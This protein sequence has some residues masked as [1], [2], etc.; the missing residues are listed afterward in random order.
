MSQ[1]TGQMPDICSGFKQN[2]ILI[3]FQWLQKEKKQLS[4]TPMYNGATKRK[5]KEQETCNR[6]SKNSTR[7]LAIVAEYN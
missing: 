3:I 4:I 5:I 1:G 2:F 7:K 6:E